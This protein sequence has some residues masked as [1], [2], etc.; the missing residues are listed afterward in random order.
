MAMS[1][2]DDSNKKPN[3]DM[4]EALR[5]AQEQGTTS[6][7]HDNRDG[8]LYRF[9]SMNADPDSSGFRQ[10][11]KLRGRIEQILNNVAATM[12][13]YPTQNARKE[14]MTPYDDFFENGH[15]EEYKLGHH[16]LLIEV[17][18]TMPGSLKLVIRCPDLERRIDPSDK[19]QYQGMQS[20]PRPFSID[21]MAGLYYDPRKHASD[22]Q[23]VAVLPDNEL[24][25]SSIFM[26]LVMFSDA[27]GLAFYVQGISTD[28]LTFVFLDQ[29]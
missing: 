14:T 24:F 4:G 11:N 5:A 18:F 29:E 19:P 21:A 23:Q 28:R 25:I 16:T 15:S 1:P 9:G 10:L 13:G 8:L 27:N 17:K 2:P 26:P 7:R 12:C 20:K 3:S 22:M 6:N